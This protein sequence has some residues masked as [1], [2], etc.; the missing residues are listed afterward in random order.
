M[1]TPL[2]ISPPSLPLNEVGRL[3]PVFAE[4]TPHPFGVDCLI[5]KAVP[6]SN[7]DQLIMIEKTVNCQPVFIDSVIGWIAQ[8]QQS[9]FVSVL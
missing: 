7:S 9:I 4:R 5:E 2:C 6:H 1:Q 8:V 3:I